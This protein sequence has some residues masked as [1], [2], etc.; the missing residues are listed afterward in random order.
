MGGAKHSWRSSRT[1]AERGYG[2][3]WQRARLAYLREHPLCSMHDRL[4]FAVPATVVDH[5]E[6]HRGDMVKFWDESNWQSLCKHCHDSH[7]KRLEL[8]GVEIGCDADGMP[9]DKGHHWQTQ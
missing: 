2:A 1:T 4:G 3:R 6:P 9:I 7:K 5:V 8:S